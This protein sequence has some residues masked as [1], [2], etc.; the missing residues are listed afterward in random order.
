MANSRQIVLEV[1]YTVVAELNEGALDGD[2]VDLVRTGMT[3]QAPRDSMDIDAPGVHI[4]ETSGPDVS[5]VDSDD[6]VDDDADMVGTTSGTPGTTTP[7]PVVQPE[8]P[9]IEVLDP[10]QLD[11][12]DLLPGEKKAH[13]PHKPIPVEVHPARL[14]PVADVK[15]LAGLQMDDLATALESLEHFLNAT[16]EVIDLNNAE[17]QDWEV[18]PEGTFDMERLLPMDSLTLRSYT[19]GCAALGISPEEP[20]LWWDWMCG[21]SIL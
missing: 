11:L 20:R 2:A 9:L 8:L 16:A 1:A 14:K 15:S 3:I 7:P 12:L 21:G 19:Q 5:I 10:R 13:P 4:I 18:F 6:E 17:V